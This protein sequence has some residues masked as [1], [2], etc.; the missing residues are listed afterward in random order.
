MIVSVTKIK[1]KSLLTSMSLFTV[2]YRLKKQMKEAK[3][4]KYRSLKLFRIAYTMTLWRDLEHMLQFRDN[5]EHKAVM[6]DIA[7]IAVSAGYV[8]YESEKAPSWRSAINTLN[9]KGKKVNY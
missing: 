7:K 1:T 8:S 3:C 5:G 2:E 6:K 9:E 4:L